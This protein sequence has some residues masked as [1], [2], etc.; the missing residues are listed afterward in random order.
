M[1][2]AAQLV[3]CDQDPEDVV[4][5]GDM[6]LL[7]GKLLE[8]EII[9]LAE[10]RRCKDGFVVDVGAF[11]FAVGIELDFEGDFGRLFSQSQG[12]FGK[13]VVVANRKGGENVGDVAST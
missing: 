8:D 1:D 11:I 6:V 12:G 7:F 13:L 2:T 9:A 4:F 3:E 5:A 10:E